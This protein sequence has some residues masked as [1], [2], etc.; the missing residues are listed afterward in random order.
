ML[1]LLSHGPA[2]V[3]VWHDGVP[4]Q[5]DAFLGRV[6]ALAA[7]LPARRFAINLCESRYHFLLGFCAALLRGQTTLLPPNRA[8]KVIAEIAADYPDSYRLS[9]ADLQDAGDTRDGAIPRIPRAQVAAIVFTSG[10]TG[11]ARP[12]AKR[13]DMLVTGAQLTLERLGLAGSPRTTV[14][15]TVPPQHMFGLETSVLLP[16]IGGLGVQ[17]ERPFFPADVQRALTA[18]PA[19][20]VLITTP[21]HLR[22]LVEAGLRWPETGFVLS[23]TAPLPAALA[24]QGEQ[25]FAAPVFEI[26]GSSET[27]AVA[28][29]RTAQEDTWTTLSGVELRA[30][31]DAFQVHGPQLSEPV[32]LNDVFRLAAPNRFQVLGRQSDMLNIAGKRASL[33][34]L[35]HKLLN[36]PG[37]QDGAFVQLDPDGE[38][39]TR[40]A[41]VVVAP[42]LT[43]A[44][45]LEKL[46]DSMD[47]VFLPRPLLKVERLPRN[48]TGK[49]PRNELLAL[50]RTKG[51]GT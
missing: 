9:D 37:V 14:V 49:L 28:T 31:A 39:V 23:S 5:R 4:V 19:P 3:V 34:D 21:L 38:P 35:N 40:L 47:P 43:T 11:K 48:D 17:S 13:W 15:A 22:A 8:D 29:R 10:S 12:N 51:T 36:I 20:R 46:R 24:E 18:A 44:Q 1:P 45:M 25:A 7:Q 27:G 30:V 2:D 16:L 32:T 50:L 26:F 6:H 33:G 42:G 41:A